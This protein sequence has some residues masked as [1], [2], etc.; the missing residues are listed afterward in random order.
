MGGD[1]MQTEKE[2]LQVRLP[3]GSSQK[4]KVLA[5]KTGTSISAIVQEAL[6]QWWRQNPKALE[7]GALFPTESTAATPVV[8][9]KPSSAT[10]EKAGDNS[11]TFP[12]APR[13]QPK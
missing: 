8:A 1:N 12:K 4:L 2:P 5:A 9:S 7:E 10:V 3:K 11:T 6:D 13:K